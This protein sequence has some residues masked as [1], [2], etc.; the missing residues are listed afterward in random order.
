MPVFSLVFRWI[1]SPV[2]LGLGEDFGLP[3]SAGPWLGHE[4]PG[5]VWTELDI[6]VHQCEEGTN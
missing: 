1:L 2:A 5:G 6:L 4:A 3:G